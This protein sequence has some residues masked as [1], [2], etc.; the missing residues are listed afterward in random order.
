M[1]IGRAL[2]FPGSINV[3]IMAISVQMNLARLCSVVQSFY[4]N[5]FEYPCVNACTYIYTNLISIRCKYL[6]FSI[7]L[8]L[9]FVLF[10]GCIAPSC[11]HSLYIH[12]S[13]MHLHTFRPTMHSSCA[14]LMCV[15]AL[16][17]YTIAHLGTHSI[18]TQMGH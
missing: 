3:S 11:V 16:L 13:F 8:G 14:S 18:H 2:H 9:L 7:V 12:V 5:F 4:V 15:H 1:L 17:A 10:H 6:Q